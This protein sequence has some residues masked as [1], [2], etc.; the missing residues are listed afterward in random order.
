MAMSQVK[1]DYADR[2]AHLVEIPELHHA[3]W[4]GEAVMVSKG[5]IA[6]ILL[7]IISGLLAAVTYAAQPAAA[8]KHTHKMAVSPMS[9]VDDK[10]G[11]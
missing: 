1:K 3:H 5:M 7:I 8:A 2:S 6:M 4:H 11:E 10:G 9:L